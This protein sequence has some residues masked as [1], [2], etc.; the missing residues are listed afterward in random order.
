MVLLG[1]TLKGGKYGKH[2]KDFYKVANRVNRKYENDSRKK[3]DFFFPSNEGS[4]NRIYW[5][6]WQ[7]INELF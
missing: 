1:Y 5:E 4:L 7:K 6:K 3:D 2:G